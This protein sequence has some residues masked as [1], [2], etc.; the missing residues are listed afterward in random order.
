MIQRCRN[1]AKAYFYPRPF[2]PT[3]FSWNVEWFEASGKGQLYS[4]AINY[5]PPPFMGAEPYVIIIVELDEG[6]RMM[7]NLIGTDP[8]PAKIVCDMPVS[9][10]YDNV[11]EEVTLPKFRL[12]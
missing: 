3:C 9:I 7:S 5:R 8:D 11:T 2:C 1:C 6:P 4:F 12:T 10:D